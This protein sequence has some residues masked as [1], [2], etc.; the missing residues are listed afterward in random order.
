MHVINLS[1]MF[2]I[3]HACYQTIMHII[4]LSCM[5]SPGDYHSLSLNR[6]QFHQPKVTPLIN[7][8]EVTSQRL[9][10]C[11]STPGDDA[12]VVKLESSA[13]LI[14][15][16]ILHKKNSPEVYRRNNNWP[17]TLPWRTPDATLTSLLGQQSTITCCD[18]YYRNCVNIDTTAPPIPTGQSLYINP[19]WVTLL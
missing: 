2:S 5:H 8:D 3:F 13:K 18:L 4:N 12:T 10:Y 17:K 11:N 16:V 6:I 14:S 15:L 1:C 7:L 19:W 9:C